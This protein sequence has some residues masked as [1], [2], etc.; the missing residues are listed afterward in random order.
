MSLDYCRQLYCLRLFIGVENW[1]NTLFFH[2]SLASAANLNASVLYDSIFG[3]MQSY[4]APTP[5]I[6]KR[7]S[8][9]FMS[10][11]TIFT[12]LLTDILIDNMAIRFEVLH[13]SLLGTSSAPRHDLCHYTDANLVDS[14]L[15]ISRGRWLCT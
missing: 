5:S 12:V 4:N 10:W 15:P 1:I 9:H 7:R 2:N 3:H 14:H 11:P 6:G 8:C 13:Y